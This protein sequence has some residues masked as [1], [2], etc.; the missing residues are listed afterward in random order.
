[1]RLGPGLDPETADRPARLARAARARHRLHRAGHERGAELVA[2]GRPRELGPGYFVEPTLFDDVPDDI[3]IAREEIFGPVLVA[4]PFD[5]ARGGR[6]ARQRHRVRARRRRL[7]EGHR[8]RAPARRGA[9]RG[10]VWVNCFNVCDAAAPFGG[11]KHSGYG[12]ENGR[13]GLDEFLQ[14][15]SVWTNLA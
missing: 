6:R 8:Q 9:A 7:D 3:A 14:S 11:Y 13:E 12:R 10:T 4:Q 2:G 5:V 15:K 1:M